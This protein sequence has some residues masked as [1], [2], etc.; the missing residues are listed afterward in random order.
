MYH[1]IADVVS[2]PWEIAVSAKHFEEH[3]QVLKND[4]TVQ[5]VKQL[6]NQVSARRVAD[7][8]ICIT[9]DD[10]YRDNFEL[11]KPILE[12]YNC[13]ATFFIATGF[14]GSQ[15]QF[16][17]DELAA[18]FLNTSQLPATLS[19]TIGENELSYQLND[20]DTTEDCL[21][22]TQRW[23]WPNKPPTQRCS[24][25]LDI[26]KRLQTSAHEEILM[27]LETLRKWSGNA[28][29]T[30][31]G[32]PMTADQLSR[33]MEAPLFTVG[34]HTAHHPALAHH[35]AEFQQAE[36]KASREYFNKEHGRNVDILA[37][38]YG[39]YNGDTLSVVK[40]QK[41][42][43]AFTTES[44]LVDKHTKLLTTGRFQVRN[45]SGKEFRKQLNTWLNGF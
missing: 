20:D 4:F 2:D 5:P 27:V 14:I 29:T 30:G 40:E 8:S 28:A 15:N 18:I 35:P 38:P 42:L 37:Y 41:L 13:P 25:Y 43:A 10:G 39:N 9:F 6:I 22:S 19:I 32:G 16:W 24:T 36:I 45:W 7:K 11:A 12:R 3:L 44:R 1:R 31:D 17:W 23:V 33:L 21:L 34:L 26:W